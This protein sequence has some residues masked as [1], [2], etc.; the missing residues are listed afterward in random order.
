[1]RALLS[2]YDKTAIVA[3][4]ERLIELG[5]E[6]VSTGGTLHALQT[7]GVPALA[8]ADVTGSPEILDGRVKT[9]HPA[10]HGGLLA[11]RDDPAHLASLAEHAIVPI[12]L[13][14]VNLY[15]FA[16]TVAAPRVGLSDALE[17]IDVGGPT[18]IRAAAKNF[19][20]VIVLTDPADYRPVL[21][22]LCAG[23]LPLALRRQLAA[24]AFAHVA[25]YDAVIAG[26]LSDDA[27]PTE[28]TIAG[29]KV[30]D[31]RYGEN[32]QQRAASYRRRVPGTPQPGVL[33]AAQL[34]GKELSFNNL[35]DA[36]AAWNAATAFAEP[37]V[38]IVKHAIPCGLASRGS[39]EAAF[40]A[41][42]A[43]D[44][45]SAFGGIV[46]ANRPLDAA[47]ARQLG[48]VFLEVVIA[49][50]FTAEA[51]A[52]LERKKQL[53]L[54][55]MPPVP[56]APPRAPWDVRVIGGG[57]LVQDADDAADDPAGWTIV[58][59]HQPDAAAWDDL[60]FAW[61]VVR[62]VKS[63]AIVLVKDRALVGVGS[64]Q[65]N[66]LV[67]VRLAAETAGFR[68]AG[69]VLASDAFFPFADGVE[70]AV[71]AGVTAIIQPGGSVRDAEVIAAADA[72]GI[73]MAFT[74]IRHF[75]H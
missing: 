70:T 21:D 51:R 50:G 25:A 14:A 37:T 4:A 2:V 18:M 58:T 15:P 62:F 3:L 33:D 56:A 19:P 7:A 59:K 30:Q 35:L 72:A 34:A 45:I 64:G 26:Y 23:P 39:L 29:N 49:P 52:A 69:A 63:N 42:L 1:M 36:D 54:L 55:E 60:R 44:P 75:R 32:P 24:R 10:I 46:A 11:R 13:V 71:A 41:A 6:I 8:V 38:A 65:P 43:G 74:G 16:Q 40:V 73:S 48:E 47:T 22:T 67:S 5:Y 31:L 53:R 27:F 20:G 17:Q 28:L 61:Q 68:A 66:R 9:L 12:D 57:F